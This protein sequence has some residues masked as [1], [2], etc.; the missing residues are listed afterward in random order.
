MSGSKEENIAKHNHERQTVQDALLKMALNI[1]A[2][3]VV[4]V[5]ISLKIIY[6]KSVTQCTVLVCNNESIEYII[7][8]HYS[9]VK[10]VFL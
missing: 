2:Y 9:C 5:V 10:L 8:N 7:D 4:V 3:F 1:C 6:S